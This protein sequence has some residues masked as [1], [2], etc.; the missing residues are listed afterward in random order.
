MRL[1]KMFYVMALAAFVMVA[2]NAS[3]V[4]LS[5]GRAP[6]DRVSGGFFKFV[7]FDEVAGTAGSNTAEAVPTANNPATFS[8]TEIKWEERL[9]TGVVLTN[10][11]NRLTGE[12]D[13]GSRPVG[14]ISNVSYCEVVQKRF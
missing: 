14:A 6:E 13:T 8:T 12:L 5:C 3:P 9:Q 11:L 1:Q 10:V 4:N 7:H 2:A